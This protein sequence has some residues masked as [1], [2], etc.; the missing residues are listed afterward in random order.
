MAALR[1][2]LN[3]AWDVKGGRPFVR[4]KLVDLA[5]VAASFPALAVMVAV[6]L[7]ARVASRSSHHLPQPLELLTAPAAD[8]LADT[9]YASLSCGTCRQ[10][11]RYCLYPDTGTTIEMGVVSA[12]Q[13]R[14]R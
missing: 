6:T 8:L 4:G 1:A 14:T 7:L 2:G 11:S 12:G 3:Q 10:A 9:S 13:R 5:L